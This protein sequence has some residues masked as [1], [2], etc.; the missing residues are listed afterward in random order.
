MFSEV[1]SFTDPQQ[2]ASSILGWNQ[3]YDQLSRGGLKSELQQVSADRFQI[4]R[5]VLDKSVVQHGSAP[6][7]R[8]CIAMSL[9]AGRAPVVQGREVG[10]HSVVL[11]RDGEEFLLHAPAGTCLFAANVDTVRFAKL[12]ALEL[13]TEQLSLLQTMPQVGISDRVLQRFQQR[14]H[15]VFKCLLDR[16]G[17][18]ISVASEKVLEDT[19]LD[20]FL[21]LFSNAKEEERRGRQGNIAVSSY[22]VKR[23]QELALSSS[24]TPLTI[25][26]LCEQ[27]RV[28]RR[29]L[30]KSFQVIAGI[31]P[32]EYL[33][34]VRLN[35]VR[36]RLNST[37]ASQY[38]VG[39][40][41]AEM[42]FYH[43]SHF[44]G[45]YRELFGEYPS[46]TQRAH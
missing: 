44:A 34:S 26:D 7:G 14:I 15:P 22:L 6:K 13:S 38:N 21:D 43:L 9:G 39:E 11:L 31:R 35:A 20:A 37:L 28:S 42:G 19:L 29:T 12:A 46:Q 3:I 10:A 18:D 4:F 25:L 16:S 36:R 27:L 32:V 24:A 8:L 1:C 41:A 2:H 17:D 23:S 45:S 5:E 40:I 30:Q 33:R